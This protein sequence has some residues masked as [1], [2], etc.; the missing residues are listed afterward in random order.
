[1]NKVR[2]LSW[3]FGVVL[4]LC[5]SYDPARAQ[6]RETFVSGVGHDTGTTCDS[7]APCRTFQYAH[8][9][10]F[11]GGTVFTLD[12]ADYGPVFITKSI[13]IINEN[14]GSAAIA[15]PPF[16]RTTA[17]VGA[18]V[19]TAGNTGVV[20]LRGL[21]LGG[22]GFL[23]AGVLVTNAQQVHIEH[24][25]I[26]DWASGGVV[27]S[28]STNGQ[29][30]SLTTSLN[31]KIEDTVFT[32]NEVTNIPGPGGGAH[33]ASA[34]GVSVNAS[35]VRSSFHDNTFGIM[36]DGHSG[37]TIRAVISDS[38]ISMNS[39][40]GVTAASGPGNV[41]THITRST[42]SSNG[43]FGM[44]SDQTSGA[45]ATVTVNAST[46]TSNLSGAVNA[47]AGGAAQTYG[48]NQV[49]GVEG[50]GFTGPIALQ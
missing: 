6:S 14:A 20:T 2:L 8:D 1:M 50:T 46:I 25:V 34:A 26:T 3:L 48:N 23:V 18:V 43:Q 19:I 49:F 12:A 17:G 32:A 16:S 33:I 13:N 5:L 22:S 45:K 31:L 38:A 36:F 42:I 40:N 4:L 29:S 27:V 30:Q 35:I 9:N 28:P 15:I 7:S 11:A 44:V 10:T 24:C 37:G 21:T 41:T 39:G 47:V